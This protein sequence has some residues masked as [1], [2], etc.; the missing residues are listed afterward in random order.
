M[1]NRVDEYKVNLVK[2]FL[3]I[4]YILNIIVLGVVFFYTSV[5]LLLILG[6]NVK[7]ASDIRSTLL[8]AMAASLITVI[9]SFLGLK[10]HKMGLYI[11]GI[12]LASILTIALIK[13]SGNIT[14]I[15]ASI[16]MLLFLISFLFYKIHDK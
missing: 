13:P 1:T 6:I 16:P 14:K 9:G 10:K 3:K 4:S 8:L 7:I 5:A 2:I 11:T 12:G 15:A